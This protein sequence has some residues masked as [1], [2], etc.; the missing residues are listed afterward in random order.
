M[1][2]VRRG[3]RCRGEKGRCEPRSRRGEAAACFKALIRALEKTAYGEQRSETLGTPGCEA[4]CRA[5]RWWAVLDLRSLG[6]IFFFAAP[7]SQIRISSTSSGV[8]T[9]RSRNPN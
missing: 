5:C 1:E 7:A 3:S 6:T 9:L 2:P 8:V 4:Q